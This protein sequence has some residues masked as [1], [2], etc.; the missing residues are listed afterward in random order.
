MKKNN[1]AIR[2]FLSETFSWLFKKKV[3]LV[4]PAYNEEE[5]IA[6]V[7]KEAKKVF[8]ISEIIVVDDGSTD[9]T[10]KIATKN[11]ATVIKH[12]KN[13]GKGRAIKTGIRNAREE[14]ILF[15]D[16]DLK[17]ITKQKIV[18]IIEP[19]LNNEA[20]FVKA[21]FGRSSGRVTELT[22]KPL[23]KELFPRI[24]MEQPLSG[25]FCARKELLKKLKISPKWGVD[26]EILI[27]VIHK[28]YRIKQVN[29]GEIEH[30]QRALHELKPMAEHVAKTILKKYEKARK[31]QIIAFDMDNTLLKGRTIDLI[32]EKF[33]FKKEI[34]KLRDK[35]KKGRIT[36]EQISEKIAKLLK[37]RN[38]KDILNAAKKIKFAKNAVE[39]IRRL[40]KTYK[41][42]IIS[43][44]YKPVCKYFADKLKLKY[45]CPMLEVK[46]SRITGKVI[47]PKEFIGFCR[48]H[49]I[50]KTNV[51]EHLAKDKHI[52]L[53]KI[54]AVGD[55]KGDACMLKNA[56]L[57]IAV[58]ADSHARKSANIEIKDLKEIALV[59]K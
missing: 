48:K 28:K 50:C 34:K 12:H 18:N 2:A 47:M 4:I 6:H 35:F 20:D 16:A 42:I 51:L 33:G 53:G 59:L 14:V 25:Q 30:I 27:D 29:I 57:G 13:F 24:N 41:I 21:S 9:N 49:R 46:K 3:S 55:S 36:D 40:K 44:S 5:T 17:N 45:F 54:V 8:E 15:L 43:M 32:A 37:G 1:K 56:G 19:V 38:E 10:V 58:N 11:G 39:T 23:L 31:Y 52:K 22:A 26:I 7:I